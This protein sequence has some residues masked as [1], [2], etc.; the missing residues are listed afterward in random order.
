MVELREEGLLQ[1]DR[2]DVY[3]LAAPVHLAHIR[4][5]KHF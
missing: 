1:V 4:L 5:E 2:I 3:C